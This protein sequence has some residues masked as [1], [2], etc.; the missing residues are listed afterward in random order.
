M[1][2]DAVLF[3]RRSERLEELTYEDSDVLSVGQ[4]I[5]N[6]LTTSFHINTMKQKLF[7]VSLMDI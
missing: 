6:C 4:C 3:C 1:I 2:P 5:P 7:N